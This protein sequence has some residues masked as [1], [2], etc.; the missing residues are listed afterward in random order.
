MGATF[1][2]NRC[3]DGLVSTWFELPLKMTVN[4]LFRANWRESLKVC[5]WPTR[6]IRQRQAVTGRTG[7]SRG[8]SRHQ[9][10]DGRNTSDSGRW[11]GSLD[12]GRAPT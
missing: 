5:N 6:S 11:R 9:S 7:R 1:Q 3:E 4:G 2:A 12:N 8:R 10:E